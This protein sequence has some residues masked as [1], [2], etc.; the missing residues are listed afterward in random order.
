LYSKC[1]GIRLYNKFST[2]IVQVRLYNYYSA[3]L[4]SKF[5]DKS[6]Q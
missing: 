6:V 1:A 3:K 4:Y 5:T 2:K